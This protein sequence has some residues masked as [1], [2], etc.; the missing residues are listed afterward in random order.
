M[1]VLAF[2]HI[3]K[4]GG[5]TLIRI[6]RRN[7]GVDHFDV[8]PSSKNSMLIDANDLARVRSL[9]PKCAS[10]AGHS[11]RAYSDISAGEYDLQFYTLLRD[12]IKRY[13]S[14]YRHFV[15]VLDYPDDFS[16]WLHR[17]DRCNFQTKAIA[18]CDDVALAK[19]LLVSRFMLVGLV[20]Q[21]DG[22]LLNMRES[23]GPLRFDTRYE[24]SNAAVAR[25]SRQ[26]SSVDF[27]RYSRQISQRNE[28]DIELYNFV[29]DSLIPDQ[30]SRQGNGAEAPASRWSLFANNWLN[31]LYRN[32]VYK[33]AVGRMPF[34]G[35]SLPAYL[36]YR[37]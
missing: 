21:F 26:S 4:C 29:R 36:P 14:D 23:L 3:E 35:H 13:I 2:A 8:I 20:E 9:R 30:A 33:P 16:A 15:E 34:R 27:D 31:F 6:L 28:L 24:I 10:I 11:V 17:D 1:V 37:R 19:E 12:P 5:T 25:N 18:G 22:F 32:M 7:F